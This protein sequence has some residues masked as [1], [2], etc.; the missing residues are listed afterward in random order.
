MVPANDTRLLRDGEVISFGGAQFVFYSSPR[1]FDILS[2]SS[3]V[4]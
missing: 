2:S 3:V 4:R 1:I